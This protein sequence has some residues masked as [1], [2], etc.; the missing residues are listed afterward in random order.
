M[1]ER[2]WTC[3]GADS[4]FPGHGSSL[5]PGGR[6]DAGQV[7]LRSRARQG[8]LGVLAEQFGVTDILNGVC[9]LLK[10]LHMVW[11]RPGR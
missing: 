7:K 8:Y 9:E 5:S 11:I 1:D 4:G 3:S 10:R 2:Y 6:A